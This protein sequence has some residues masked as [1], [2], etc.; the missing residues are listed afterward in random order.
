MI[1]RVWYLGVGHMASQNLWHR[2]NI[3]LLL[4]AGLMVGD[5]PID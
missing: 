5:L 4:Q 1:L 3:P 2:L